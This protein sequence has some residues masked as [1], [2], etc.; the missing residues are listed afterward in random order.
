MALHLIEHP[1][2]WCVSSSEFYTDS[3]PKHLNADTH[4][5]TKTPFKRHKIKCNKEHNFEPKKS[6]IKYINKSYRKLLR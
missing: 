6:V 4:F 5:C 1:Q 3:K 2:F